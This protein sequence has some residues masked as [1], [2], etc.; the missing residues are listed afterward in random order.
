M[1]SKVFSRDIA[2]KKEIK[3]VGNTVSVTTIG[4]FPKEVD[5]TDRD[6]VQISATNAVHTA[7]G[8]YDLIKGAC[9]PQN[10]NSLAN[11]YVEMH[12]A[13]AGLV[14]EIYMKSIIYNENL[15]N[16]KKFKGHKLDELFQTLP[17]NTQEKIKET[18]PNIDIKLPLV[19][20]VFETLRY[21]FELNSIQGEYPMVF[22]LMEIL[23]AIS[24]G[25]PQKPICTV[26]F[27]QGATS[28]E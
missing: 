26:R 18:I 14:C 19:G 16:G 20:N 9:N 28:I 3:R 1:K 21:D 5:Y 15:H 10:P 4:P 11:E 25:Y 23:R 22:E 7:N 24:N 17:E 8:L 12:Y 13:L 27:I 2:I 6:S